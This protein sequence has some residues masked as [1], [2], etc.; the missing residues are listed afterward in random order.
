MGFTEFALKAL[1]LKDIERTGWKVRKVSRPES[2]ADHSFFLALLCSLYADQEKLNAQKCIELA[3]AHDLHE[4][5]CGD[6]C[7]RE[8][9]H[10]QELTNREKEECERKAINGFSGLMPERQ[11]QKFK[12]L[13]LE[14]TEQR[15]P[16]AKFVRDMDLVEMCLQAL[17]YEK[18]GRI[19]GDN[20]DFFRKTERE[21]STKTGKRLFSEIKAE[22]NGLAGFSF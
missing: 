16:E 20:S 1:E 17:F 22:F 9:E 5:V 11:K 3:L 14:Y 7:S 6:I 19:E 8:F 12:S 13:A 2:V 15:T 21:L 18:N 10:E 4:T